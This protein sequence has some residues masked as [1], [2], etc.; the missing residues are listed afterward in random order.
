MIAFRMN[1]SVLDGQISMY[2]IIIVVLYKED[3]KYDFGQQKQII[4]KLFHLCM[5]LMKEL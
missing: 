3:K 1:G 5:V 2:L 4:A